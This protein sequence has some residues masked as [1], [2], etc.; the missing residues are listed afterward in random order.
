MLTLIL[1]QFDVALKSIRTLGKAGAVGNI[2][3]PCNGYGDLF[4]QY[5]AIPIQY[6]K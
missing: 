1:I 3:L 2:V 6:M 4:Y 5:I